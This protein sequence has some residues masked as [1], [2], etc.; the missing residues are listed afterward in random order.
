MMF[1]VLPLPQVYFSCLCMRLPTR[2]VIGFVEHVHMYNANQGN[3]MQNDSDLNFEPSLSRSE[4]QEQDNGTAVFDALSPLPLSHP[5]ALDSIS[6]SSTCYRDMREV[7]LMLEPHSHASASIERSPISQAF[8][9]HTAHVRALSAD[10]DGISM[11]TK[12]S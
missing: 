8:E 2:C 3:S 6:P 12:M 11:C 5:P 4:D 1:L 9:A 7:S 10:S